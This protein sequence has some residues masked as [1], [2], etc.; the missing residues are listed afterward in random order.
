[1][2][3]NPEHWTVKQFL[4]NAWRNHSKKILRKRF[5]Y[6][7]IFFF[8]VFLIKMN[9]F[10]CISLSIAVFPASIAI[11]SQGIN[12]A[13]LVSLIW[14][15]IVIW[16]DLIC[17]RYQLHPKYFFAC[18]LSSI[19]SIWIILQYSILKKDSLKLE[20]YVFNASMLLGLLFFHFVSNSMRVVIKLSP[21][22][23]PLNLISELK[24]S[25]C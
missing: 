9:K 24:L 16:A 1:M 8:W 10:G 18:A 17:K 2:K 22:L 3:S 4:E 20:H 19:I 23:T 11:A 15:W 13:S 14:I 12:V 21:K 5:K 6:S 7:K 25:K